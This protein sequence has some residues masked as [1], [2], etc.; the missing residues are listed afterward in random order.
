MMMPSYQP[1]ALSALGAA[2]NVPNERNRRYLRVTT[3]RIDG[4]DEPSLAY[5]VDCPRRGCVGIDVCVACPESGRIRYHR[6]GR[7][8]IAIECTHVGLPSRPKPK[9]ELVVHRHSEDALDQYTVG[10]LLGAARVFVVPGLGL[11]QVAGFL[12]LRGLQQVAVV[13]ERRQPVGILSLCDTLRAPRKD[14][15]KLTVAHAMRPVKHTLPTSASVLAALSLIW[16]HRLH[17]LALTRP[18][19][20]A[21]GIVSEFELLRQIESLLED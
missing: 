14:D 2:R 16:E 7:G 4:S 13:D 21:A 10:E 3:E 19:G 17:A 5:L 6:R 12:R 1:S 8:P 18:S 15:V 20:E 11:N 9:L